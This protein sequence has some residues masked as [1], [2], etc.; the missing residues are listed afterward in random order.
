M[1]IMFNPAGTPTELTTPITM[2]KTSVR[3]WKL[4]FGQ[5]ILIKPNPAHCTN[6]ETGCSLRNKLQ[7]SVKLLE[8]ALV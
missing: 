8:T 3:S 7:S 6:K 4:K 2:L 5:I 1:I